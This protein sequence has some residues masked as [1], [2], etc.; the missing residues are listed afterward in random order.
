M[1]LEK[2]RAFIIHF[3]YCFIC[4]GLIYCALQY[5]LP[6][7]APFLLAFL[8]A[9]LI[10]RPAAFLSQKW[11]V[12]YKLVSLVLLTIFYGC[13]GLLLSYLGMRLTL[14]LTNFFEALPVIYTNSISPVLSSIFTAAEDLILRMD[15][16]SLFQRLEALEL[17]FLQSGSAMISDMSLLAV[18]RITFFAASLPASLIKV[19]LMVISSYFIVADY[20]CIIKFCLRQLNSKTQDI[21]HQVKSYVVNTLFVCIRSYFLIMTITFFELMLGLWILNVERFVLIALLISIFDIFPVLGVGGVLVPWGILS[22][23][24]SHYSL[25]LGLFILYAVIIVIRNILEPRI[26]G[27]QIG[28]HP[29]VTLTSMFAGAQL[30]GIL[31]L[32]GFPIGLSLLRYL[33]TSGV[34]HIFKEKEVHSSSVSNQ[35]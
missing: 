9:S 17:Q 8:L 14:W 3:L 2:K 34:I 28:L 35:I 22:I 26:V 13:I 23:L 27:K 15:D 25:A 21:F 33:N 10:H 18:E 24:Q 11:N 16:F 19:L 6:L 31:G 29:V 30:F 7:V 5:V 12:H 4:I 1:E 20:E 32:F